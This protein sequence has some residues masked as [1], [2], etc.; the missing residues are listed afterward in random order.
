M[1]A[2]CRDI[3]A[4]ITDRALFTLFP[5]PLFYLHTRVKR[6][7][8][9][10]RE[11]RRELKRIDIR[12]SSTK[13]V[14]VGSAAKREKREGGDVSALDENGSQKWTWECP[15]HPFESTW[16]SCIGR[17]GLS[18]WTLSRQIEISFRPEFRMDIGRER[19]DRFR[20]WIYGCWER[21][22]DADFRKRRFFLLLINDNEKL[23]DSIFF[24]FFQYFNEIIL[25]F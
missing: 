24:F 7:G 15:L 6:D 9:I 2:K 1:P 11:G 19:S 3:A 4:I 8:E 5:F 14:S 12:N 20:R 18:V 23:W 17:L 21:E 22:R 13:K 16:K 25:I 10:D